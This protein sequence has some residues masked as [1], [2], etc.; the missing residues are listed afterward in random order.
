M[1]TEHVL[2]PVRPGQEDAFEAAFT[3]AKRQ[4]ALPAH[5]SLDVGVNQ[6]L[7]AGFA[8]LHGVVLAEATGRTYV[9]EQTIADPGSGTKRSTT[10]VAR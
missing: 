9:A 6:L 7:P 3:I 1:I 10:G 5:S 4:I 2:L 8:P